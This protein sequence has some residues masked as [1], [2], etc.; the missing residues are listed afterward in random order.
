[1][2]Q[3]MRFRSVA[4]L[5]TAS[6]PFPSDNC[7]GKWVDLE[8]SPA[9]PYQTCITDEKSYEGSGFGE[10]NVAGGSAVNFKFSLVDPVTHELVHAPKLMLKFYGLTVGAASEAGMSIFA[11]GYEDYFLS[12]HSTIAVAAGEGGGT[13]AAGDSG[14][15]S[16]KLPDSPT[17]ADDDDDSRAVSLLFI[18][19]SSVE[20]RLK[21]EES[22]GET[23]RRF[24]FSMKGCF[25]TGSCCEVD[26]CHLYNKPAVD[27]ILSDWSEWG[28]CD[29]SCG[30]G[31]QVKERT[32][33]Q[34]PSKGGFGCS[35][36]LS[37][38]RQCANQPC[39][40]E[41][42]PTDCLWTD[43]S[44]WGACNQCGGER[45]R[46]R[47][48]S[49]HP[50]CGGQA[51][52]HGNAVEVAKCPRTCTDKTYCIWESWS[53]YGPCTA[54]CGAGQQS[55]TRRLHPTTQ[56]PGSDDGLGSDSYSDL[57]HVSDVSDLPVDLGT[58]DDGAPYVDGSSYA[59]G[60][61]YVAGGSDAD[62]VS[63]SDG[64]SDSARTSYLDGAT[65]GY[66]SMDSFS[67]LP[68][69]HADL[70]DGSE[71]EKK[72]EE[73]KLRTQSME[74]GRNKVL[75]LAFG[76]GAATLCAAAAV[77]VEEPP[78]L[79]DAMWP[80]VSAPTPAMASSR[81][82]LRPL[83]FGT[84]GFPPRH[85]KI[86]APSVPLSE[87]DFQKRLRPNKLVTYFDT[88]VL[89]YRD[90][91]SLMTTGILAAVSTTAS[92][93]RRTWWYA[94]SSCAFAL[95][96]YHFTGAGRPAFSEATRDLF[97]NMTHSV[98]TVTVFLLGFFL[99]ACINRWWAMRND[100]IG[101]LWGAIND[102]TLLLTS[103]FP[104]DSPE[105]TL[106]RERML[107]WAVLSHELM[108]KQAMQDEDLSDLLQCGLLEEEER[109]VLAPLPSKGQ[110]V[111]AWA[112]SY[113][114][115]LAQ[116]PVDQG[117]SCLPFPVTTM[118][119]LQRLCC[120]ARG[121]LGAT[122]AY[123]DTQVPLRYMHG[124]YIVVAMHNVLQGITS[125]VV[126]AR[127]LSR[128]TY[129]TAAVEVICVLF[130]PVVFAG[131]LHLGA[132][133]LNP[134]R[135]CRDTDFPRGAFSYYILAENRAF[136]QGC[137]QMNHKW[138]LGAR[139]PGAASSDASL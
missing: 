17:T 18:E 48:I 61:P 78:A 66:S 49:Q 76:A 23:C 57:S 102:L 101:R 93:L 128:Q 103:Y 111:W 122:L 14:P 126:I 24:L 35:A 75:A 41:C 33:I 56:A 109:K 11:T 92:F 82:F 59:D 106:V 53:E 36:A 132:G 62:S 44:H 105:D 115:H 134:L 121:G 127:A 117:G 72:F 63:Y 74:K 114:A 67:S 133:M 129:V 120:Q 112:T 98:R 108:Y 124:L 71:L 2:S 21:V 130:F 123:V 118:P 70:L 30:T 87:A 38:T 34:P 19:A 32:I 26:P 137:S 31:Q 15:D 60:T 81:A 85:R 1:M 89:K 58:Y 29:A 107:R 97:V 65:K 116:G 10:I 100:C 43:W 90:D 50:A 37:I 113:I 28:S 39:H 25:G 52:H 20:V 131:L 139:P 91:D 22:G 69:E 40:D 5:P 104:S 12:Q 6:C 68:L 3:T 99:A 96:I 110:V 47:H 79:E 51:C 73:L 84:S 7:P 80:M 125:V 135:S 64:A 46:V 138:R 16:L 27:C 8:V 54:T 77:R 4:E 88:Q 94:V 13:F 95:L 42:I 119:E 55:R 45:Q 136:H 9:S 86:A 83:A